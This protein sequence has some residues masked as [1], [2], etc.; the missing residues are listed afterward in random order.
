MECVVLVPLARS[1]SLRSRGSLREPAAIGQTRPIGITDCPVGNRFYPVARDVV[2]K[3]EQVAKVI[4]QLWYG[5]FL[6]DKY[7]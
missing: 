5:G 2:L 7:A 4:Q 1:A 6:L 3:L